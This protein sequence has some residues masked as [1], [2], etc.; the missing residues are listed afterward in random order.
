MYCSRCGAPNA[1]VAR[2]CEKCGAG[3]APPPGAPAGGATGAAPQTAHEPLPP[4]G[5][6]SPQWQA[7][8]PQGGYY[9]PRVRGGAQ[10]QPGLPVT[11]ADGRLYASGKNPVVAVLLSFLIPGVGQFY[12]GDSKKG[13]IMLGAW[14]VSV[15][16]TTVAVGIVG[17]IVVWIWSMVDAYKVATG[18]T[19]LSS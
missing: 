2:F 17:I 3:L 9:D 8:P 19:P 16:L 5:T 14:F 13:A 6:P 18:K 7:P 10:Y 11:G 15:I 12:N 1:D 4:S